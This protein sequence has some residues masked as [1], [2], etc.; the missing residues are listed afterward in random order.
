MNSVFKLRV[1][2][3]SAARTNR[4]LDAINTDLEA[5]DK[6][7]LTEARENAIT[8]LIQIGDESFNLH[9][10]IRAENLPNGNEFSEEDCDYI[11]Q[12]LDFI[13]GK[14]VPF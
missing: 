5:S 1:V 7:Q 9:K 13:Y 10:M 14:M 8:A 11:L 2:D 4:L 6:F 12:F 3:D